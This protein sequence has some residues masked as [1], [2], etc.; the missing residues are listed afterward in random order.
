MKTRWLNSLIGMALVAGIAVSSVPSVLQAQVS[1]Q[2]VNME[3]GSQQ[4]INCPTKL[5]FSMSR[6]RKTMT[7][8]CAPASGP[9]ATP[10]KTA[11]PTSTAQPTNTAQPTKT[12]PPP[13]QTAMPTHTV[14]PPTSTPPPTQPGPTAT[15]APGGDTFPAVNALI[16]GTCSAAVHDRYATT[17]PDGKKYRTWH[18]VTVPVDPND[19]SKGTC[20]FAHEHGDQPH[21]GGP[22]PA[23]GYAAAVHGMFNE[24]A[25]HAGFKVFSHYA[26]GSSGMGGPE[27]D[28]RGLAID[29]TVVIHQGSAGRG[30]LTESMHSLEFWS[31][32]Q[33]RETHIYSMANTGTLSGKGCDSGQ[34]IM[35][36]IVVDSC[37]PQYETWGF[38]TNIGGAWSVG[39]IAAVTNPMN[40][41]SGSTP[42]ADA[43][44]SNITLL[45]TSENVCGNQI[46]ACDNR[47][48][49]GKHDHGLEN[50]WLG[51]Q[52]TI[53]EPDW[54]WSNNGGAEFFCTDAMGMRT[55]CGPNT[56]RQQV[57]TVSVSNAQA[58]QLLRTANDSGWDNT[59]WLP[60]GAPG[61]N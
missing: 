28:Y 61:G 25:A 47:L 35:S 4:T 58:S 10:T 45:S 22:L 17:G 41:M 3:P 60:L 6:D 23:F 7:V 2:T 1:T 44:C 19:A 5:T 14:Q 11:Q 33:N 34:D 26:N 8:K 43:T 54:V 36:R 32:Y 50:F 52:R 40:H 49:F 39:M 13:T 59:Y 15:P 57:A 55:E 31:R 53:H 18:P 42:C 9:T 24:I 21:T 38:S 56:I 29:F 48:P 20:T 51:N 37:A 16:L 12:V 30:R 27:S 46:V